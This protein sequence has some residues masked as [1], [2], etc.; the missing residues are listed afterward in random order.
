MYNQPNAQGVAHYTLASNRNA[1]QRTPVGWK[2]I[3]IV[4]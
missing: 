1:E 3:F 2:S 4:C